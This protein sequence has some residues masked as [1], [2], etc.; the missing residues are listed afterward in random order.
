MTHYPFS[1]VKPVLLLIAALGALI[2]SLACGGDDGNGGE[3]AASF[4]VGGGAG[5]RSEVETFDVSMGD[6]LFDPTVFTVRGGATAKF[7]IANPG[8][9]I[10]NMRLAGADNVYNNEDDAISD[11]TLVNGGETAV[12]EWVTPVF[13]GTFDFR[14]DFHPGVMLGTV[15]VEPAGE[16][17]GAGGEGP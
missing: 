2:V 11:P 8:A 3:P 10:H 14:C 15:T 12:L 13:G 9:A 4:P 1:Q 6:N 16:E 17:T 7:N 5:D